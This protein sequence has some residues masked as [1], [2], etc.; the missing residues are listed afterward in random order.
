[1]SD[2]MITRDEVEAIR[3]RWYPGKLV[4]T[5]L[6]QIGEVVNAVRDLR[7]LL[8]R[9]DSLEEQLREARFDAYGKEK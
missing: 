3:A 1:M 8:Q 9:I 4:P 6:Y 7:K 5:D 2:A